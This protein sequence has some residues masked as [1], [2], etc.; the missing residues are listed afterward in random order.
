[1]TPSLTTPNHS[2]PDDLT[3]TIHLVVDP[4][5]W[6]GVSLDPEMVSA[7]LQ[8]RLRG[9]A[10]LPVTARTIEEHWWE[11]L[12]QGPCIAVLFLSR[13]LHPGWVLP[14][15]AWLSSTHLLYVTFRD[16]AS[17]ADLQ[18]L[19]ALTAHQPI[20]R[21]PYRIAQQNA[22]GLDYAMAWIEDLLMK[23]QP[24]IV[25]EAPPPPVR[26]AGNRWRNLPSNR[27]DFHAYD[28]EYTVS[29]QGAMGYRLMAASRRGKTHAHHGT[30]R[31]DAVAIGV[32][33]YWNILSV[34]DG[35]GTAPLARVGSN[36]AV[37]SAIAAVQK[38]MP[39][40]PQPDDIG[41]AV[42][43]GIRAAHTAIHHFAADENLP[44]SDLHTTFQL[45]I[46]FPTETSCFI[47]LIQVGDGIV[48]AEGVDGK[49][50]VLTDPDNDP[51]D[52]ARTLFL[53]SAPVRNWLGRAKVYQFE[54]RLNLVTLMTDG[55][56]GDLEPF[57]DRLQSHLFEALRQQVLCYPPQ[58]REMALLDYI[59]YERRGSFDDRTLAVLSRQ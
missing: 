37:T 31:E 24:T 41:Q 4:R 51:D 57:P 5:G 40:R 16:G 29:A 36:L 43:A 53:T 58:H 3:P 26:I 59:S 11:N 18:Q 35:A 6:A 8:A 46:H 47:G 39:S 2:I 55:V 13:P 20:A 50:Y 38:A 28:D 45:V 19:A 9:S 10:P 52:S 48:A 33:P 42:W 54:D 32:N 14:L 34:A 49:L 44:V 22:S 12:P 15:Q 7:V 1:M 23:M 25:P 56:A 27:Q 30:F 17:A 21:A